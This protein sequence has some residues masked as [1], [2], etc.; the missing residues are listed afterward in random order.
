MTGWS[1][2]IRAFL[3][4][5]L[6]AVVV[7]AL[8]TGMIHWGKVEILPAA[9]VTVTGTSKLDQTP[10]I[11]DFSAA[12]SIADDDKATAVNLVNSKMTDIVSSLKAFG[13]ADADIQTQEVSVYANPQPVEM[14]YP[15]R[16]VATK[17]WQASNSLTIKLRDVSKASGLTDLLNSSGATSVSGPNYTIENTTASDPILLA[18]AVADAKKNAQA[19]AQAGGRSLGK[20]I[21]VTE[22][23]SNPVVYPMMAAGKADTSSV[24]SPV[25]P[26]TETLSKT[27]TAVFELK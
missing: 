13:I 20:L 14:M 23:Y 8:Y 6:V 15:T 22:G 2:R 5:F 16:P 25:Q 19:I 7:F 12:V 1:L 17:K 27:V 10:Q 26:G 9:T 18:D 4:A 3:A 24:P 21:T 11:A